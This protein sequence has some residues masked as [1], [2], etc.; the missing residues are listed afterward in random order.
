MILGGRTCILR[1]KLERIDDKKTKL[2]GVCDVSEK[3]KKA[4]DV[5]IDKFLVLVG[6]SL[7]GAE[8]TENEIN[9][10]RSGNLGSGC[11]GVVVFCFLL[12]LTV[13]SRYAFAGS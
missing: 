9:G 4:F 5:Y 7:Q 2:T 10:L 8:F 12:L 1:V 13:F 3:Y 6:R 11:L